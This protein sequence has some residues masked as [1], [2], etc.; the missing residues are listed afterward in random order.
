MKRDM[1][2]LPYKKRSRIG[3]DIA[4]LVD[5]VFMLLIFF[6]LTSSYLNPSI[7]IKLP[8][9]ENKRTISS[10]KDI[11]TVTRD[12]KIYL[13][14]EKV[15]LENLKKLLVNKLKYS[16]KKEIFFRGDENIPYRIFVRI[17]DIAKASGANDIHVVHRW[18]KGEKRE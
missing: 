2:Y 11:I 4:P 6:I 16:E 9:A 18:A 3:L 1:F 7:G 12:Q 15:T 10:Q 8:E 5:I 17:M 13:N 14:R